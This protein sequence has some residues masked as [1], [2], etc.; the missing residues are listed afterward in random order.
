MKILETKSLH[1]LNGCVPVAYCMSGHHSPIFHPIA[2]T[3]RTSTVFHVCA[4][5]AVNCSLRTMFYLLNFLLVFL[6]NIVVPGS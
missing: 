2:W 3:P 1:I 5:L 6:L 4:L